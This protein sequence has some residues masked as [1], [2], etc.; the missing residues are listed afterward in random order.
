[1]HLRRTI[2]YFSDCPFF[3]GCENMLANFFDNPEI[4]RTYDVLFM[5]RWSREYEDGLKKRVSSPVSTTPL[6]LHDH[7]EL[8]KK[9]DEIRVT[10]LRKPLK[11]LVNLLLVKY[12]F[13]IA[14]TF[15]LRR[16]LKGRRVDLIHINSGG[17]P[18]AYSSYAMV[19]AARWCGIRRVVFVVN[20]VAA[21]YES[22]ERWLD[23]FIDRIIILPSPVIFVTGSAFAG[24]R[25]GEVL[26]IPASRIV[27][28]HNGIAPRPVTESREE[29]MRR[30]ALPA[31]RLIVSVI[32]VLEERKGH[33]Y[34]LEALKA[35]KSEHPAGPLPFCIIE[36]TGPMEAE[37]KQFVT[38]ND[39]C[40][41]VRFIAH[42]E[43]VFNL[44]HASDCIV[45]PSVRNEDF[46]NIVLEAMSLGKVVIASRFS[47]IP[48]QIEDRVSGILVEPGDTRGIAE[49]L[50]LVQDEKI[51]QE[52]G[53]QARERFQ[54]LFTDKRAMENYQQLYSRIFEEAEA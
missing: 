6:R 16:T 4:R 8:Y 51:R 29:T 49:A 50:R 12:F 40:G 28:I 15:T 19:I 20:N 53:M 42:E 17:Y 39:L 14:N 37:L 54:E 46:P 38:E 22:P 10:F 36:G 31:G 25:L 48:E 11:V 43:K 23:F 33:R 18:G 3:A 9:I 26:K 27:S 44:I 30:L 1:V 2:L 21:G 35:L 32:A 5:Y 7:F 34:L 24:A 41:D 13:L 52:M 45:L 47:G